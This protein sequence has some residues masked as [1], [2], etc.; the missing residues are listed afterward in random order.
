M[1]RK[2]KAPTD[3][4]LGLGSL[5]NPNTLS[6]FPRKPLLK[7]VKKGVLDEL[8][9]LNLFEGNPVIYLFDKLRMITK[10]S[11]RGS[12][13]TT[14][15]HACHDVN[16]RPWYDTLIYKAMEGDADGDRGS[17]NCAG[18]LNPAFASLNV[19]LMAR[20]NL[21]LIRL[22]A[23]YYSLISHLCRSCHGVFATGLPKW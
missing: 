16:G 21:L 13:H 20:L 8:T 2:F 5:F 23:A 17:F 19:S 6:I 4:V 14:I 3:E 1:S 9:R 7:G 11:Y 15:F 12:T 22:K 18:R 10:G